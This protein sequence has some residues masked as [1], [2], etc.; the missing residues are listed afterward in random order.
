VGN[1]ETGYSNQESG[2]CGIRRRARYPV[3][4]SSIFEVP[5]CFYESGLADDLYTAAFVL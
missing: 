5:L 3:P 1:A 2:E 4:V